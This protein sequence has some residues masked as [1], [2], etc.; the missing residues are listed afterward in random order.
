MNNKVYH[1]TS[2]LEV[3]ER[4]MSINLIDFT[5]DTNQALA[6][7]KNNELRLG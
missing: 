1:S 3:I 2:Q 6:F 7:G 5:P 4:D